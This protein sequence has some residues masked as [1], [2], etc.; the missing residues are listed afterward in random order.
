MKIV[1]TIL[2]VIAV[3]IYLFVKIKKANYNDGLPDIKDVECQCNDCKCN[4]LNE[5]Y[6]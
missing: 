4:E 6:P 2:A 1:V 3:I 5:P